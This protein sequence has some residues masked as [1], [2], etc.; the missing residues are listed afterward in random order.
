MGSLAT[1]EQP[2]RYLPFTVAE[3]P[4]VDGEE[5]DAVYDF[6]T[7]L[8]TEP[9]AGKG[10][11]LRLAAGPPGCYGAVGQSGSVDVVCK[12]GLFKF[13]ATVIKMATTSLAQSGALSAGGKLLSKIAHRRELASDEEATD[14]LVARSLQPA[15]EGQSVQPRNP[16][17]FK[18][19][20]KVFKAIGIGKK[21]G[22][23]APSA[24]PA[25]HPT[26][27][28]PSAPHPE[29]PKPAPHHEDSPPPHPSPDGQ[30]P[31]KFDK[32]MGYVG[33]AANVAMLG[34]M[35]AG[36]VQSVGGSSA[37]AARSLADDDKGEQLV[38]RSEKIWHVAGGA[39][40]LL[41]LANMS[42][43][44]FDSVV[45]IFPKRTPR[46]NQV[47][48]ANDAYDELL[49]KRHVAG[50]ALL[51]REALDDVLV[52]RQEKSQPAAGRPPAGSPPA[53]SPPAGSPPAKFHVMA[54]S[55]TLLGGMFA[56]SSAQEYIPPMFRETKRLMKKG[57]RKLG[58]IRRTRTIVA[59]PAGRENII[60]ARDFIC[61]SC[62]LVVGNGKEGQ[63]EEML[64]RRGMGRMV[65][66]VKGV[67]PRQVSK[68]L[69][70]ETA[71]KGVTIAM[72]AGMANPAI[73]F[74]VTKTR[75][76]LGL[77]KPAARPQPQS[78]PP[79]L[80]QVQRRSLVASADDAMDTLWKRKINLGAVAKKAL[81]TTLTLGK[82]LLR[83]SQPGEAASV[84]LVRRA[85]SSMVR[86]AHLS[87]R[88]AST[89]RPESAS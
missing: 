57:A 63:G 40:T 60:A 51:R 13:G 19:I 9:T 3:L 25:P 72:L 42:K 26:A 45:G 17:K 23:P 27:P 12:R 69:T 21:G 6:A 54:A 74:A 10:Q 36:V 34:S 77:N 29:A 31:S 50:S 2:V 66:S 15:Y 73:D 4:R 68:Y 76:L 41:M 8:N 53:G 78:P 67:L 81:D 59:G 85:V 56:L 61:Q 55:S 64:L 70:M 86:S 71:N 11:F 83:R 79:T 58:I 32:T 38:R 14:M 24:H 48:T 65:H 33:H 7:R 80:L 89:N 52:K 75:N 46:P 1:T 49:V 22:K 5:V 62:L 16:Q 47:R 87:K 39:T 37:P 84:V 88:A 82:S 20:N 43:Q 30:K 28:A 35:G 18:H 44:T